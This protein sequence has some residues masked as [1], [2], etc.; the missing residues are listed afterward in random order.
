MTYCYILSFAFSLFFSLLLTPLVGRLAQRYDVLDTPG[1]RKIHYR[2]IPRWGGIGIYLAFAL[3]LGLLFEVNGIFRLLLSYRYHMIQKYLVGVLIGS[4]IIV[5]L[6]AVDDKRPLLPVTKLLGQIIC[7][8]IILEY[9]VKIYG[10]GNPF[11]QGYI[12][13][14]IIVGTV[15]TVLWMLFFINS[16]NLIDGMDGL[17]AGI[18]AIASIIFFIITMLQI[19]HQKDVTIVKGMKLVGVLAACLAGSTIGF[20][21]YNFHPAKIFMGDSGSMFLGYILGCVTI[22]GTLKVAAAI[23]VI[24]PVVAIG[25]P[26]LDTAIVILRRFRRK[27]PI[28]QADR[29]HLHHLFLDIGIPHRKIVVIFYLASVLLGVI[30]VVLAIHK[31]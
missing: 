3:S 17:A 18:V 25:I 27:T 21:R 1:K 19:H 4:G 14:P 2:F 23:A 28:F 30:A 16:V 10:I 12:K 13:F 31:L 29:R 26:F 5:F 11:G 15:V 24:I 20:L 22:L 6:G 8:L 7:V 9:G